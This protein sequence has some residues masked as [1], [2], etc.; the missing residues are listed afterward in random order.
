M[1]LAFIGYMGSGKSSIGRSL[2]ELL[3]IPLVDLDAYIETKEGDSISNIFRNQGVI[4]FRRKESDYLKEIC[5]SNTDMIL[6]VGG[7]TPVYGSNMDLLNGSFTT[8]YLR[9]NVPTLSSR[10]QNDREH[11]PLIAH[12]ADGELSEFIGKHLFERGKFYEKSKLVV[13]VNDKSET[14]VLSDVKKLIESE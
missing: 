2:S 8:L 10:L 4:Y 9:A 11:R 5:S 14:E 7:G 3:N 13:D 1:R 12:L 6:S